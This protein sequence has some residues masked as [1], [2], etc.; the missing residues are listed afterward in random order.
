M[1]AQPDNETGGTSGLRC[2]ATL[3]RQLTVLG[4]GGH[5]IYTETYD[6]IFSVSIACRTFERITLEFPRNA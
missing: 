4:G 6:N 3:R 1:L 2:Q 5:F